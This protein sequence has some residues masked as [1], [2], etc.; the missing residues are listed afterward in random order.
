MKKRWTILVWM[1]LGFTAFAIPGWL[2]L[3]EWQKWRLAYALEG[4]WELTEGFSKTV[5]E[6]LDLNGK[7][8]ITRR[9]GYELE[10]M[11]VNRLKVMPDKTEEEVEVEV[12]VVN[13][14]TVDSPHTLLWWGGELEVEL[15]DRGQTLVVRDKRTQ[16][17]DVYRR[18]R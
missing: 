14:V 9:N 10:W 4:E 15:L 17:A 6:V 13:T 7:L 2:A 12:E 11:A 18:V 8:V 1:L 3:N 5:G 16:F